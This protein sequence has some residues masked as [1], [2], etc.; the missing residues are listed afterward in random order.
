MWW[1]MYPL[2]VLAVWNFIVF[3]VYGA[4]KLKAIRGGQRIKEAVLLASAGVFGALGGMFGMLVFRH[5]IR[6]TKFISVYF[7]AVIQAVAVVL[8]YIY[9]VPL[10]PF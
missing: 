5:K 10:L 4:D 6:K 3:T 9:F 1:G 7:M 2:I 8:I